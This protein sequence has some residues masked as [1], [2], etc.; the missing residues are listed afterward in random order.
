MVRVAIDI[1]QDPAR[2]SE[3]DWFRF[4]LDLYFLRYRRGR[5]LEVWCD[6]PADR[7]VPFDC[8]ILCDVFDGD[9][10][11]A[12]AMSDKKGLFGDLVETC[13]EDMCYVLEDFPRLKEELQLDRDVRFVPL[14]GR[15]KEITEWG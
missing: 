2:V 11:L 8:F 12:K 5:K 13:K 9:D 6:Y 10:A 1:G 14:D 3:W 7:Q 4:R 15:G